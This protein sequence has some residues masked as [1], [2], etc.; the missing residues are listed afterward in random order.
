MQCDE[1]FIGSK[2]AYRFSQVNGQISIE[3]S[4]EKAKTKTQSFTPLV[5]LRNPQREAQ[6][7]LGKFVLRSGYVAVVM[8]MSSL[9]L[10]QILRQHEQQFAWQGL[11]VV[12]ADVL[13]AEKLFSEYSA[14]FSQ[15]P[16]ITCKNLEQIETFL[17]FFKAEELLGYRIFFSPPII[18]VDADFYGQAEQK[19]KQGFSSRLSDLFTRLEFEQLW[20]GNAFAQVTSLQKA[21]PVG[22]LF[23]VCAPNSRESFGSSSTIQ[24]DGHFSHATSSAKPPSS[25]NNTN[26]GIDND[27]SDNTHPQDI[28]AAILV[29]SGPSLRASLPWLRKNQNNVFIAC[30]D[31]AYRVLYNSGIV[32]H[33]IMSL[34]A[35]IFT[36]R[37][38]FGLPRG[39]EKSF[40]FLYAD[41]VANPQVTRSWQ[42]PLFAGMSANYNKKDFTF[43]AEKESD[44]TNENSVKKNHSDKGR[45][46]TVGCDFLEIFF[47]WPKANIPGDIQ[48][49][50]SVSTSLF[51]LLRNMGFQEI[52][53]LGQDSGFTH[54]EFHCM[55]TH[56]SEQWLP[57]LTRTKTLENINFKLVQKRHT[58]LL[59]SMRAKKIKADYVM[60]LYRS[61]FE[62]AAP[63]LS[64]RL[65]NLAEEGV[66]IAGVPQVTY[67]DVPMR[68]RALQT[69]LKKIITV[70]QKKETAIVSHQQAEDF[71]EFL[72]NSDMFLSAGK[73]E[74]TAWQNHNFEFSKL[75]QKIG[76]KHLLK[77]KRN[78]H[79][80]EKE[81]QILQERASKEQKKFIKRLRKLFV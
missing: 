36:A 22:H 59:T 10:V 35:Q 74:T 71:F 18:K 68:P 44:Y 14:L 19:I 6:R 75:L 42:G 76:R 26:T 1:I 27:A 60:S 58:A 21:Y 17:D 62:Q 46:V 2:G 72:K 67:A 30:V 31:S 81:K 45:E 50:G 73:M 63:L 55:G 4:S 78:E 3:W 16:I 32:P 65:Y 61:W 29:S 15:I 39:E 51:D 11:L 41:I 20:I 28:A 5:S 38:F 40:P 49:G 12:E 7:L 24:T 77:A 48:S 8:G 43:A 25:K 54:G 13:L 34:D 37:H 53:L 57:A 47:N 69:L 56:H 9:S 70:S 66:P 52:Y 80:S 64:L 23:S 33:L 79:L